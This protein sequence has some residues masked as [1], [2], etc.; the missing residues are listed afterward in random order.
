MAKKTPMTTL[1]CPDH[2]ELLI[3]FPRVEFHDGRA[4]TDPETAQTVIDEL[5]DDYGI[6]LAAEVPAEG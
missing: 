2:P 5:G 6:A 3:T 4:E 1:T